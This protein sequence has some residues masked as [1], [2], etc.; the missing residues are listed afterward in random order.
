MCNINLMEISIL[1]VVILHYLLKFKSELS[2]ISGYVTDVER[3]IIQSQAYLTRRVGIG[4]ISKLVEFFLEK[5]KIKF[6]S[7]AKRLKSGELSCCQGVKIALSE[8]YFGNDDSDVNSQNKQKKEFS[9]SFFNLNKDLLAAT[10]K[11]CFYKHKQSEIKS[12]GFPCSDNQ[13]VF[14]FLYTY[15]LTQ[16]DNEIFSYLSQ[17]Q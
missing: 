9:P 10:I 3:S 12:Q 15:I 8:N 5:N 17:S 7:C 14:S 16:S 2:G 11:I 1:S 6:E 4:R 13:D